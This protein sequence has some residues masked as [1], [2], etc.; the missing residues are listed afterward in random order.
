[1]TLRHGSRRSVRLFPASTAVKYLHS[2][3]LSMKFGLKVHHTDVDRLLYLRPDA[4]EF[5]LFHGDL[6]GEW[7]DRIDFTGPVI[8]H[9]PEKFADGTILDAGA[10][11]EVQ[12]ARA[13]EMLER[14]IDLS[15]R[16]KAEK[17]ICHPGGVF[18]EHRPI[19]PDNLVRTMVELKAYAGDRIE[20][21][22][23][24]M[25]GYYRTRGQL[26]HPCLLARSDEL[27][28][29]LNRVEAGLC[30]DVCHAKL[31]CNVSGES[32]ERY[33]ETLL[34]YARHLHVSDA[35]GEA[36]EGLQIGEGEIDWIALYYQTQGLDLIAVPE[37]DD[38]FREDGKG[39]RIARDRL[40]D[41]GFYR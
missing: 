13:V 16:L 28:D 18:P 39:F 40:S 21:L 19:S 14:T 31:Y 1:M 25:P 30:L 6:G 35:L 26:W 11:D 10:E 9:A 5:A 4:L 3:Y 23:E 17:L 36:G 33:V 34:P 29:V 15:I 8:V 12:R 24:N 37:I 22:L 41:T 32:F 20:L 27:V 7:V 2:N 38:G